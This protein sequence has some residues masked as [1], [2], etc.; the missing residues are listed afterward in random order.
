[1]KYQLPSRDP[2]P[3]YQRPTFRDELTP[4]FKDLIG[5]VVLAVLVFLNMVLILGL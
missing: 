2:L 3:D 4:L 5:G 1:M